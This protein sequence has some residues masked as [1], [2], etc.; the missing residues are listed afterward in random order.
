[1]V[2]LS[3][4]LVL[5]RSDS[6]YNLAVRRILTFLVYGT[7]LIPT[8]SISSAQVSKQG[9]AS[10]GLT[11]VDQGMK[12]AESGHCTAALPLLKK[13]IRQIADKALLKRAG[14]D[15]V[16]CAMTGNNPYE[17]LDFLQILLR[18]FP[19]DPEVLYIATHAYSDLA[20]RTSQDL[21]REAPFSFQVH[22]LNA[23]ALETQGRWDEAAA[24]YRKILDVNPL[25]PGIHARLGRV[26]LSA[27][28]PTGEAVAQA[29]KNFED[30]V[31]IDPNNASAEYVLG[32]L[33][34]D[35]SDFTTAI[36]HYTRA[37]KIDSGFAEAYL[38]L[39]TALVAQ[40]Q[41]AQAIPPLETYEKMA[42]DSPTGHFQLALA[43]NGVGRK[44]DANREAALQRETAKNLEQLKRRVAEG[45]E[46]QKPPQ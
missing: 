23:E 4:V 11:P 36:R 31:S 14:L 13:T 21:M 24:E 46:R 9:S 8:A 28:Q 25:L 30:E 34:K 33:A 2:F 7:F 19:R 10:T 22:Q 44:E 37:T 3:R 35:D 17:S 40:Q 1:M 26:L 45:L 6:A 38:G 41:F 20:L 27:Q 32:E 39:G 15:G 29:K 42:P 16:H 12:L 18:D 43:Y 5:G